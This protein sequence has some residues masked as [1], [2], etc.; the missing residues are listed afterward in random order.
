[1]ENRVVRLVADVR[2]PAVTAD[3]D[4]LRRVLENFV[5]NAIR[6]APE[7]SE[8]KLL[9]QRGAAGAIDLRII[10]AG[11]GVPPEQ[12]EA[13]FERYAQLESGS[14]SLDRARGGRGRPF[15]S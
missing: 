2:V 8:V 3:P 13:V 7:E 4:L 12:R 6:H 1:A 5:E 14:G 9:A 15:C 10:D 11:T